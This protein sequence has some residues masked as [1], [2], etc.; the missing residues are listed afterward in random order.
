M[1]EI[2]EGGC[3]CGA[4]RYRAHGPLRA[5]IACHCHQ[6]RRQS[7]HFAAYTSVARAGDLELTRTDGLKW[8][9]S[10]ATA[11]RGFCERCGSALFWKPVDR[12]R[13]S[14]S[15]GSIEG[16][17][18]VRIAA[19]FHCVSKGDYYDIPDGETQLATE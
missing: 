3:L 8:F 2:H 12:D 11:S 16:P 1:S 7:G 14:I 17:T 4:V 5:V 18:G 19:H 9:Q 6:C 13:V 10:S 15:A